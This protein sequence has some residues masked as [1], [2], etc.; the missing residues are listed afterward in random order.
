[1]APIVLLTD[2]GGA[3]PYP[4]AMK[5]VILGI[6][7]RATIVDLT[8]E[9]PPQD[10]RA[11]AFVLA[12][13]HGYF[14]RG[15]IFVCVV[16]PGI[17]TSRRIVFVE[18]GGRRFLAP[19]NGLLTLVLREHPTARARLVSNRRLFLPQVSATFHGRDVFAPVAARLARGLPP[20][21]L[22]PPV[23]AIERF[24][25]SEPVRR[26]ASLR[27]EILYVDPFGNAITN[28]RDE[29]VCEIRI[30]RRRIARVV[31]TYADLAEGEI[32][33]LRG[34]SGYFEIVLR[35][36]SAAKKLGVAVGQALDARLG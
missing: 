22:G 20:A 11:A 15:T 24:P 26:G 2:F 36:G 9:V 33:L 17:G 18:A 23:R 19:D 1:V 10:V 31:R 16:D 34:S 30:G 4:A 32:G 13:A 8:H 3:G 14:P 27:G 25:V 35:N 6:H 5:G 21:K 29:P 28:L 12:A 7:A